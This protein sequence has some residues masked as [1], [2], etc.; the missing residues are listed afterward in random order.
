MLRLLPGSKEKG[1]TE[2]NSNSEEQASHMVE[3]VPAAEISGR[4]KCIISLRG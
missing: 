3:A 4:E 2:K 1:R